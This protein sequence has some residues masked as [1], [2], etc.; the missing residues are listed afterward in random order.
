[1]EARGPARSFSSPPSFVMSSATLANRRVVEAASR[2]YRSAERS[3][4]PWN[5]HIEGMTSADQRSDT[6]LLLAARTCSEPFGVFYERHFASVL[7]F[8][9][10]RA[11][12]PE[13]AF[14]LAAE[15]FAAALASVPRFE[16]G[17]EPPRAWL[18]AIARH[19]LSEALRS[20]R[21]RDEARRALAMQPIQLDDEAIEILEATARAPA[22]EL[23][24]TLVPEQ[25]D[26]VKAHHLE[27]RGY[28]EIAAEL[29]CSE[30]VIR[31]RV[32]RGLAALQAQLRKGEAS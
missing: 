10:R 27:E 6:E 15:T 18:F 3:Q 17:P 1:M 11:P 8:F 32:S 25:R 26:A 2:G 28:G 23:L 13:E 12:G 22:V 29:R 31:K 5:R 9:R 16:P 21:I 7:A 20:S 19:T 4:I 30:S 24:E 14:D